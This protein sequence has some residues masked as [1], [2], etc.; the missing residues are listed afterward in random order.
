MKPCES[1]WVFFF[2]RN[3][4]KT[5]GAVM[6]TR[7]FHENARVFF[8]FEISRVFTSIY[9]FH[10]AAHLSVLTAKNHEDHLADLLCSFTH[11]L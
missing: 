3:P 11:D 1:T 2:K 10:M 5:L 7:D 4:V 8:F 6:K 9:L